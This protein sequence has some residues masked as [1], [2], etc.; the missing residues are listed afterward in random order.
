[1]KISHLHSIIEKEMSNQLKQTDTINQALTP[2]EQQ[3][4]QSPQEI[5][6]MQKTS[7]KLA[8]IYNHIESSKKEL[9]IRPA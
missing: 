8:D 2:I 3:S 9:K 6:V 4:A 1:M 7:H 5:E